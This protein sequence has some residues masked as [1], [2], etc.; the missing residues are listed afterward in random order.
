MLA[1][2]KSLAR[3][4]KHRYSKI[5]RKGRNVATVAASVSLW[6]SAANAGILL[7]SANIAQQEFHSPGGESSV[8]VALNGSG[9]TKLSFTTSQANQ[10]VLITLAAGC[11]L[12]SPSALPAGAFATVT[13]LVDPAGSV[14]EFAAPPTSGPFGATLCRGDGRGWDGGTGAIVASVRPAQAGTN[15]VRVR[16]TFGPGGTST[17]EAFLSLFET[18]LAVTF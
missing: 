12:S 16:V 10:R 7:F 4:P 14:G 1:L 2:A 17:A 13:I 3:G 18:S 6:A 8:F 11:R 5:F 9:A 15:T